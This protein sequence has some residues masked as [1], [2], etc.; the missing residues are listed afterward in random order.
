MI[1]LAVLLLTLALFAPKKVIDRITGRAKKEINSLE[2]SKFEDIVIIKDLKETNYVLRYK[3]LAIKEMQ[4]TGIPASITLAQGIL[5]SAS[6]TSTISKEI[7]NHFGI[8]CAVNSDWWHNNCKGCSCKSYWSDTKKDMFRI[9]ESV[10]ESYKAHSDLLLA[11]KR[12]RRLL[13]CPD[14]KC[15]AYGLK[16]AG[17]AGDPLYAEK[18]IELIETKKLHIY[19]D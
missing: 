7:N 3:D 15:W 19:D 11:L 14:Y 12:Y 10:E 5:E 8:K 2:L 4:R 13:D 16:K 6:G 17:Y 1:F 9:F 18:L